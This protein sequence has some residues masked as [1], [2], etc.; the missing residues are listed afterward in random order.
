MSALLEASGVSR[1]FSVGRGLF[2]TSQTLRAV[3]DV[4]LAVGKGEVLGLVKDALTSRAAR[5][6]AL[7]RSG[8]V[9][10]LLGDPN[11]ELTPLRGN[12]LWQLGLLEMWL[13][14]HGVG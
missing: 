11:S 3:V 6:R 1:H 14:H 9:D 12:K 7:F 10:G 13:Q 8:Y 4:N 2:A 5:D